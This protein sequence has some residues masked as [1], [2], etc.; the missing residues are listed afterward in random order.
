M[1]STRYTCKVNSLKKCEYY[2][3]I[4]AVKLDIDSCTGTVQ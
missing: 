4:F 2:L 3:L 1:N